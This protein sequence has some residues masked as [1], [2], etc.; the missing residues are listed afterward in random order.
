M[1]SGHCHL[2]RIFEGSRYVIAM[3]V[4]VQSTVAACIKVAKRR[5]HGMVYRTFSFP[6]CTALHGIALQ[7][8]SAR[9]L[10]VATWFPP[11]L[12][13]VCCA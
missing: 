3:S 13:A 1:W 11:R 6:L 4:P 10:M 5:A 9:L 2:L 7:R 12:Q 8:R